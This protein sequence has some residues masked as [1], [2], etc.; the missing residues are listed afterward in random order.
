MASCSALGVL[1]GPQW[2][3]IVHALEN[4]TDFSCFTFDN[5]VWVFMLSEKRALYI[6][7]QFCCIGVSSYN[8]LE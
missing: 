5:V 2:L 3:L 6:S 1:T 4:V 7:L 8:F